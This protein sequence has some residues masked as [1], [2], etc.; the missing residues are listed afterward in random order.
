[1][2][3]GQQFEHLN[4]LSRREAGD[5]VSKAFHGVAPNHGA[6]FLFLQNHAVWS[7]RIL[8]FENPMLRFGAVLSKGKSYGAVWSDKKHQ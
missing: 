4:Y 6:V 1:M 5:E 8:G 3:Y 7:V 2:R